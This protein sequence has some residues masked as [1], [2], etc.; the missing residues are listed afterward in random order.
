MKE[1]SPIISGATISHYRII[2][3]LGAGGMGEVYLAEDTRLGRRIALKLLPESAGGDGDARRRFAQEARAAS[4]LNHP[5]I[6]TIYDVSLNDKG[7]EPSFIAMEYV[8]GQA[9]GDKPDGATLPVSEIINLAAQI[10]DALDAAHAAG[11]VHRDLKPQNVMLTAR[12]QVKVL[13]FGL[14]KLTTNAQS[15]SSQLV[16][17]PKTA[18]GTVFGTVPY[19]SPEQ[20]LGQATDCR[21]DIFSFGVVLYE[22]VTGR[23]PFNG[24]TDSEVIDAIAHAQPEA[25][26]RF[27][28][29]S[30]P[31]LERITRK[32]LEKDP[33]RRYQAAGELLVDLSNLQRDHAAKETSPR[34]LEARE[35]LL[36]SGNSAALAETISV[37]NVARGASPTVSRSVKSRALII[38][39]VLGAVLI[40]SA[41]VYVWRTSRVAPASTQA[42]IKSLAVL[43]LKSLRKDAGDDYLGL[44]IAD[45]IIT[46]VSQVGDLTVR[47]TSAVR[48]YATQEVDALEA[49]RQL[50]VDAVLDGTVQRDGD[51]LRVS[52]NLLRAA[53][54]TS[55]WAEQF[56]QSFTDIFA[57]QDEAARQVVA[58]L[59][60]RISAAAQ[61]RLNR[62]DTTNAEAYEYLLRGNYN[63]DK[64]ELVPTP[65]LETA[66]AMFKQ[67]VELDPTYAL[68]HARL[69]YCYTWKALFTDIENPQWIELA[70]EELRKAEALDPDLVELS[71]VRSEILFSRYEGFNMP[72]AIRELRRAQQID[73]NAGHENLSLLDHAGLGDAALRELQRA[74]EIDP[75]SE[76]VKGRLVESYSLVGQYDESIAADEKFFHERGPSFALLR[77]NRAGEAAEVIKE[78]L[79]KAPNDLRAQS[80]QVVLLALAGKFRE[81]DALIPALSERARNSRSYHHVTYDFACAYALAG[82]PRE[83]VEWL[84]RT[85]EYGMPDYTLFD[86]DPLLERARHDP[87]FIQF[88]QD[89]KPR[90]D[91]LKR[92]F[93][94]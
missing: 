34:D 42:N 5:H 16:T 77:K 14:A 43:P 84:R 61:S 37:A 88:M 94:N 52:V 60:R 93:D 22:L 10:A 66:V 64:R 65:E 56:D 13:D 24:N 15:D 59:Q 8:P 58:R 92:E 36:H 20:A 63:F 33:A 75:T 79:A 6:V 32:C 83:T 3:K 78:R 54:G 68:A 71:I 89:F 72:A 76:S 9:L 91:D 57:M 44:G 18:P 74:L 53:D 49:A 21:T 30:P 7:S 38:A 27:N 2:K 48:K 35:T 23:R 4:A 51:H 29:N 12:G 19:M 26:A 87:E 11:I 82:K 67:A 28:Y 55:L 90:W 69:A 86:S 40:V 81:A 85:V 25:M 41:L 45:T 31:E 80:A 46:K 47:P 62:R 17:Q 70:R 50:Q 73:P 1:S 39:A